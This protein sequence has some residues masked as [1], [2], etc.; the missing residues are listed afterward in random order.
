MKKLAK[1]AWHCVHVLKKEIT[2]TASNIQGYNIPLPWLPVGDENY[3]LMFSFINRITHIP[4]WATPE[5]YH[6][7]DKPCTSA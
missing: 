6:K 1:N 5:L 3:V 2:Y 7:L 4:F